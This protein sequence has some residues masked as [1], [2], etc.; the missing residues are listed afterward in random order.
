MP[1]QSCHQGIARALL[2]PLSWPGTCIRLWL[3]DNPLFDI[4]PVLKDGACRALCQRASKH[5]AAVW[6]GVLFKTTFDQ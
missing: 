2:P 3:F 6:A 1:E 4:L 5:R